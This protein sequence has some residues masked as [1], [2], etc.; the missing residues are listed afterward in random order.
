MGASALAGKLGSLE[1]EIEM[2]ACMP[3]AWRPK[4]NGE[5]GLD[6]C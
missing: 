1:D 4:E 3:L 2:L 5:N 6:P